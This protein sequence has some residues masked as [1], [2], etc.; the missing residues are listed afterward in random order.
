MMMKKKAGHWLRCIKTGAAKN[1]IKKLEES[2]K[3]KNKGSLI[4]L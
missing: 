1:E 2:L 4:N 3:A